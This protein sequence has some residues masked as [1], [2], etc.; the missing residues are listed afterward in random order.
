MTGRAPSDLAVEDARHRLT[1]AELEGRTNAVGHG[2]EG[3]GL[4][5]GDH[6]AV[7]VGNRTEFIEILLGVQR[8]GMVVTPLKTSWTPAEIGVVLADAGTALVAT[9][10]DAGRIAAA[11]A[12]IATLD[13]DDLEAWLGSQ[14]RTALPAAR[15]GWRMSYTSGTTGRPKGVVHAWS[16][17]SPF[18][19]AFTRSTG[20]AQAARLPGDGPHLMASQLFHGAPL[21]FGLAALAR[22]APMRIMSRWDPGDFLRQVGDGV[23]STTLVPTMFRHLLALPG[24]E[25]EAAETTAL[26][27]VLHG[28]EPC[29]PDIKR[30]MVDWLGPV[31]VEY[32]GFSEG[33]MTLATTEDWLARPGTV[34][35]A[36]PH[37]EILI[38]DDDGQPLTAGT[39]GLV[40]FRFRDGTGFSYYR[41]TGK[42]AAA[43][44]PGG[45]FTAGDIGWLDEDGYLY[46]SGRRAEVIVSA[47][48]NIYPAEVEAVLDTVD[49]IADVAVVGGPDPERGEQVVAFIVPAP[50]VDGDR[51]TAAAEATADKRLAGYKRPRRIVLCDEVPR[52]PTGKLLRTALRDTLWEGR[53]G[54]AS[55]GP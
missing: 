25:R 18:W 42:T 11:Q 20:W 15:R 48:V 36:L 5:P 39:E 51:V 46:I 27:T 34:G 17:R 29:P 9:D 33:G 28:G 45:A 2:V 37:Q 3:M 23:T 53:N 30:R 6:V 35:R 16:G 49:G 10:H 13:V 44:G 8:A 55:A 7:V 32:F 24:R 1:W 40:Y 54:F 41:D 26:R 47:G 43:Y 52:D 12:G 38:L 19:E 50:G 21:T 22:G 4:T 14:D 31:F